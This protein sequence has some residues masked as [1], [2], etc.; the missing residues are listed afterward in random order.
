MR[1]ILFRGKRSDTAA[2]ETGSLVVIRGD[3]SDEQVYIADKMTG[4]HTPV[5]P[6]TVGQYTGLDDVN[7]K[8]I[9]E[10]DVLQSHGVSPA[11]YLISFNERDAAFYKYFYD[12]FN[13]RINTKINTL[14]QKDMCPAFEIVGNIHD[15][16]ELMEETI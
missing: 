2:W 13:R 10:G 3:C 12:K 9:F 1:K 16:P 15:N 8:M 6:S 11:K 4:Y 5:M 14:F 7:G